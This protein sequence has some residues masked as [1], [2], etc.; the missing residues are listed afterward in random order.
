[1]ADIAKLTE[2][3]ALD[4]FTK[5]KGLDPYI[6]KIREEIDAFVPDT[7]T[8]KT[9]AEI[10]SM[11][12]K[13]A[14]SKVYLDSVGKD[15]V[16]KLKEQPKLVDA[17]RKRVRDTLD[18]WRDEIRA[19]LTEW[20]NAE[21]ERI[22]TIKRR[23]TAMTTLPDESEGSEAL[24]QH[25]DRLISTKIDDSFDEFIEHAALIKDRVFNDAAQALSALLAREAEQAE[26][27]KLRAE[28]EKQE[29]IDYERR[30]AEEA[31]ANAKRKAEEAAAEQI[32]KANEQKER[33]KRQAA[34]EKEKAKLLKLEQERKI[35]EAVA[36]EKHQ[37]QR[38]KEAAEQQAAQALE[39]EQRRAADK[40]HKQTIINEAA[41]S[42][43]KEFDLLSLEAAEAIVQAI[44]E[45]KIRHTIIKF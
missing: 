34:R 38:E 39:E 5:P 4:V 42:L 18:A 36:R 11:A 23:I 40:E 10:A 35:Q 14:K 19:P 41:E 27:E 3:T 31:A 9:R 29:K 15:L 24:K 7:S 28:K 32:R 13:V 22:D 37:A 20:E 6:A 43:V 17:E 1:M 33:A 30:I 44:A 2:K 25:M 26:L 21:Q 8:K 16:A 45:D 12:L